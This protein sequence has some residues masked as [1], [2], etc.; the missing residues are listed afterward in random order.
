MDHFELWTGPF[1][2]KFQ[3]YPIISNQPAHISIR[4]ILFLLSDGCFLQQN[5]TNDNFSVEYFGTQFNFTNSKRKVHFFFENDCH[6]ELKNM[7]L[8]KHSISFLRK[9][10]LFL[11]AIFVPF[12]KGF[13]K[14]EIRV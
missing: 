10:A 6:G 2:Q 9:M 12:L 5:K 14:C 11:S 1:Y 3:F 7:L 8:G 13:K 4:S